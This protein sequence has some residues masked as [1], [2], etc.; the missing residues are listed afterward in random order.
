MVAKIQRSLYFRYNTSDYH[1]ANA[2]VFASDWESDYFFMSKTGYA[3]EF[4][5]KLSRSDFKKDFEKQ[6][7]KY[8]E[9]YKKRYL[10]VRGSKTKGDL[11]SKTQERVQN[12]YGGYNKWNYEYAEATHIKIVDIQK[13]LLPN[14]FFFICPT[15]IIK[16][17]DV[18]AYAGL[19]YYEPGSLTTIK[20][21]PLIHRT[22]HNLDKILVKKFY[23]RYLSSFLNT[24]KEIS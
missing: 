19:V 21:A 1:L 20:E 23:H 12:T 5:I 24:F 8:F 13:I 18:P 16:P 9:N 2:Y 11:L 22:K 7:H 17:D 4:E 6:K 3:Y 10:V 14:R 15:G